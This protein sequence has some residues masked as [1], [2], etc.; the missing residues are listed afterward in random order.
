MTHGTHR[1][2]L[3]LYLGAA[4]GV[5]KTYAMLSEGHR[6]LGRGTDVVAA[7]VET[8]GRGPVEE[9]LRGLETVPP[10]V[11]E[12][13]TGSGETL[14]AEA[15]L[16][17]APQVALVDDLARANPRGARNPRRWQ[18]VEELLGAGIDV[19][20]TLDI[21]HLE[22]LAD[23]VE[24]IT[25]VPQQEDVPDHVVRAADQIELVD[26]TP[27]ALRRRMAHGNIFPAD[28]VDAALS[29]Y[30]RIG[31]LAAL[32]ELALLWLAD[33]VDEGLERYRRDHRIDST[34]PARERVVVALTG[35]P[36]GEALLRRGARI[37]SRG[38]GGELHALYVAGQD[39][40]VPPPDQ[41]A[42]LRVL[43]EEL[44]GQHHTVVA[45]DTAEAV[46]AVA[47]SLNASQ[48]VLGVSRR[49][50]WRGLI[51]SGV[52][53]RVIAGSED[54]DVLV[55][56]HP[57]ARQG[58]A[59]P[60][61]SG[62]LGPRR[63]AAGWLLAFA[64]PALLSMALVPTRDLP[65]LALVAMS[66][67]ALTVVC[68]LV[69]GL[70]PALAAAVL[71]SLLLN[72]FFTP[73]QNTLTIADTVNVVALAMFLL[74]AVAV[75]SV[76][77]KAARRSIQADLARR[78]ADT[79]AILNRTLLR[80]DHGV[81]AVLRL[82]Q[83]T[84]AVE[85]AALLR[86]TPEGWQALGSV[87]NEPPSR[88][89]TADAVADVS[90][91]LV[92]ALRGA[93]L[94]LHEKRVL[95]AFATHLA[96]ALERQELAERAEAARVLEDGNRVRTAL[97]AAVSHDLRTPLAG[98]K[99]AVSSLRSPEVEWS[100]SDE[101][102]LLETIEQSADRL[103]TIVAN[104]LDLS[105][106]QADVV[107]PRVH[108][109]GLDDVVSSTIAAMPR[110]ADVELRLT[111]DLPPVVADA[112]LLDRVVA[113]LVD[114][115]LRHSPPD[116]PVTVSTSHVG[117]RVQ[118]HVVDHGP[119]V[120]DKDKELMFRAFQRLGDAQG[121]EGLGLGLAV[122]SGLTEALGGLLIAEDTPGGGLTMV[123]DLPAVPT[124]D[125]EPLSP[126][127]RP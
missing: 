29:R 60:G 99:A 92:L 18:D 83:E 108:D 124:T 16:R 90:S 122:A 37:A 103:H 42:R 113:N 126:A 119:G 2:R 7:L 61:R 72:W 98:I 12:T 24:T 51:H 52:S 31:N 25:G 73:P 10:L 64:G 75:A 26:M 48:I 80:S 54:I 49:P 120:P 114:N 96:V 91:T 8:H 102:E 121:R 58:V 82:V 81:H 32:R 57:Y 74:L 41:L 84:F 4:P 127:T 45:E 38:A 27:E 43:T 110:A 55:V 123:V 30:F 11:L 104:L 95:A 109:V 115:A 107:H 89:D 62:P 125:L 116:K 105:R 9:Q 53:D 23:V 17:R 56:T 86:R 15:V 46:L 101:A 35:G 33:R 63:L 77:D 106:L 66:Y 68:A 14:D 1:G 40:P 85:A 47:R 22:S 59:L 5:G 6:R 70:W 97:L 34:W 112:G 21:E 78:E 88:P 111:P 117:D 69:G 100:E 94:Q 20:S 28:R 93:R 39:R 3:R 79:L 36:E 67:L 65:T 13:D 19:I 118:L 76:V 50:R 87:G 71:G 44:G